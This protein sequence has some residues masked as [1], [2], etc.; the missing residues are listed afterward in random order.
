MAFI[1]LPD[2]ETVDKPLK[3]QFDKVK[4]ITGEVSE[5]VRILGVRPDILDMTNHMVKTLLFSKT[6]LDIKIKEYIAILVS[7][8]NGCSICVGEH[9]RIAK[10][11]KIPDEVVSQIKDGFE[12]TPLDEAEKKLLR[13]CKKTA[14]E[15]YKVIKEDFDLLRQV[16]Y[17]DT[18]LLEAVAIVGYF[19]YINV[20]SNAMGAEK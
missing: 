18:Q 10:L 4:A 17:S 9:E 13:F 12:N 2:I 1:E 3:K 20:I 7:L 15:S 8:E 5:L 16:G 6:Q 19:N 14:R 11:L